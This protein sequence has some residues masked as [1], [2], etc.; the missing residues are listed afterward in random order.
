MDFLMKLNNS[1]KVLLLCGALTLIG[2]VVGIVRFALGRY[3]GDK[4]EEDGNDHW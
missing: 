1:E 4:D 2:L 3:R